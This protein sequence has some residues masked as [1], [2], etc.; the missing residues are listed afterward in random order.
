MA[1]QSSNIYAASDATVQDSANTTAYGGN[2]SI[3]VGGKRRTVSD[4]YTLTSALTANSHVLRLC[5]VPKNARIISIEL[6]KDASM[7]TTQGTITTRTI[8]SD[9]TLGSVVTTY[10]S[11]ATVD[12]TATGRTQ[13]V[14][15]TAA[16]DVTTATEVVIVLAPTTTN[17]TSGTVLGFIVEYIVE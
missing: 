1:S 6:L 11:G 7:G 16:M 3:E 12:L 4:S 15:T 2:S 17:T 8:N 5:R 13:Y 9:G 10:A 14:T